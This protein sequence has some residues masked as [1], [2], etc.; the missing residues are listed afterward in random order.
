MSDAVIELEHGVLGGT[1]GAPM[2]AVGDQRFPRGK[3]ISAEAGE[4]VMRG[5]DWQQR[6][7]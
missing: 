5:S 3:E 2:L 6:E 4:V 1:E 7:Q